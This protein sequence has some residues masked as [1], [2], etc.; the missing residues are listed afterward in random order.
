[1]KA[2]P[3]RGQT[4]GAPQSSEARALKVLPED[5][6][7]LGDDDE[8]LLVVIVGVDVA[9]GRVGQLQGEVMEPF[10]QVVA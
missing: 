8:G 10:G 9:D 6:E 4:T 1:M 2:W 3:F 5:A 7:A